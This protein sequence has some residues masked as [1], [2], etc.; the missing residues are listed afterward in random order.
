VNKKKLSIRR[1]IFRQQGT[2]KKISTPGNK[3]GSVSV[4]KN[5]SIRVRR[6]CAIREQSKSISAPRNKKY[7]GIRG[8]RV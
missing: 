6:Y 2:E 4:N 5:F 8:Q 7:F 1:K 3:N